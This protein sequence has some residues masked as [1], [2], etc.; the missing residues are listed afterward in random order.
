MGFRDW[1]M[2]RG[3]QIET[4]P[5]AIYV[6][7]GEDDWDKTIK[8]WRCS[9][10]SIPTATIDELI[11]SDS[12]SDSLYS[13]DRIGGVI[14]WRGGT[15]APSSLTARITLSS[16]LITEDSADKKSASA[17]I[18]VGL[19]SAAAGVVAAAI[20]GLSTYYAA[21]VKQEWKDRI[22]YVKVPCPICDKCP[23]CPRCPEDTSKREPKVKLPAFSLQ[24]A[25]G[26]WRGG[27]TT[28]VHSE[29]G[30]VSSSTGKDN[31]T[32]S[33]TVDEKNS[34]IQGTG[35]SCGNSW[36]WNVSWKCGW[37]ATDK[38]GESFIRQ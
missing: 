37:I 17:A 24:A 15:E 16:Q 11:S 2:N 9:A 4:S 21:P 33:Y 3:P 10:L 34:T 30:K 8:G 29:G 27:A 25:L 14:R 31:C 20:T 26:T 28:S 6:R 7:L 13:I 5:V 19:I 22:E 32:G 36:T 1:L 23:I 38:G 12:L 18:R 35:G